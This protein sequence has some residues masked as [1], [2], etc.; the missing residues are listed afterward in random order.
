MMVNWGT[1]QE[2]VYNKLLLTYF[3]YLLTAFTQHRSRNGT[4]TVKPSGK[5]A[6]S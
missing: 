4:N 5:N 1:V 6:E 3:T 2:H